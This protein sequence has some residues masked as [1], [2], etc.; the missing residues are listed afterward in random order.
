MG[1]KLYLHGVIPAPILPFT[2]DLRIDF[3]SFERALDYITVP[4]G[5]RALVCNGHAGE[6]A[7]LTPA[8]RG[9]VIAAAVKRV[10]GRMPII[11]GVFAQSTA[12]AIDQVRDAERHGARAALI[13][14]PTVFVGG[15]NRAPDVPIRFF[16]DIAVATS[17]PLVVFQFPPAGGWGYPPET[18]ARICEIPE[19]VGIK[20]GS[21]D[22]VAYE[23]NLRAVRNVRP[24]VAMLPSNFNWFLAQVAIGAD[25][26]LSGLASL[27]PQWFCDLWAAAQT[28]D[29]AGAQKLNDYIY[30]MIRVI[31][32]A[33]P[34]LNM[35]TR[36]KVA[37]RHLGIIATDVPRPPLLPIVH[38]EAERICRVVDAAGLTGAALC[39]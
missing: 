17:F 3:E 10:G 6:T 35:H 5:V 36:I 18:L 25:G 30:P 4:A 13:F 22:L 16:R 14:P 12:D 39:R 32:G 11:A 8:E 7:S 31:Y 33:P 21:A 15:A 19:V 23:D 29:L 37:L 34:L 20:E 28:G 26:V 9:Q 1:D 27:T 38:D 24:D 2:T